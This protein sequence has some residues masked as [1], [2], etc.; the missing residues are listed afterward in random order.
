MTLHFTPDYYAG[1]LGNI[2]AHLDGIQDAYDRLSAGLTAL[3]CQPFD[4]PH[5]I[6]SIADQMRQ[7]SEDLRSHT[8]DLQSI[9]MCLRTEARREAGEPSLQLVGGR[10][11][12]PVS[13]ALA[14]LERDVLQYQR[15]CE[16][17]NPTGAA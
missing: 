6:A 2:R 15:F 10:D 4:E 13:E 8:V 16:P 9:A 1:Q 12:K 3:A 7:A 17:T 11:F 14:R 5:A